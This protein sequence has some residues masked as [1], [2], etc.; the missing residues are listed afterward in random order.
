[1]FKNT[2]NLLGFILLIVALALG[3]LPFISS[4][5]FKRQ[6]ILLIIVYLISGIVFFRQKWFRQ[7][8]QT[9]NI[10]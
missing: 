2:L 8:L 9:V 10:I 3:T 1:M 6:D 7:E 5:L 4:K